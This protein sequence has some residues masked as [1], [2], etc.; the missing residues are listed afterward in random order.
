MSERELSEAVEVLMA[1]DPRHGNHRA[2]LQRIQQLQQQPS[3]FGCCAM[4]FANPSM[5][6]Y[7]RLQA[8]FQLKNNIT[9]RACIENLAVR[10][11]ILLSIG[12]A[13]LA[14]RKTSAAITSAAVRDGAWD[15]AFVITRL[16]ELI[17][18]GG[19][20]GN[21][22]QVHGC[23]LALSQI[24]EDCVQMLDVL[25]LSEAVIHALCPCVMYEGHEK[26][27]LL[28]LRGLT[29]FLE[30]SG[31]DQTSQSYL[32][33]SKCIVPL[34][35]TFFNN[36]QT[37]M[38]TD[39]SESAIKCLVLALTFHTQI[40]EAL[41]MRIATLMIHAS[42]VDSNTMENVRIEATEF[43][44]GVLYFPQFA[45]AVFPALP[46]IIPVLVDGMVYSNMELGMLQANAND[47]S[48]P[49]RPEDI[50]P[51]HYEARTQATNDED[52]D[53]NDDSDEVEEWNLRRVSAVALDDIAEYFGD[54]I[55]DMV[56]QVI[57]QRMQPSE[58]WRQLEAAILA[59]GAVAEGC[60]E[61]LKPYLD[62]I[63]NRLLDILENPGTHF[64]VAVIA[65][66]A[67]RRLASYLLYTQDAQGRLTKLDRYLNC[68]FAR[69]MAPSKLVQEAAC[70]ALTDVADQA[71]DGQLKQ[72]LG[73]IARTVNACLTNYQ[74][75]NRILLFEQIGSLCAVFG[76]SIGET[77]VM[78][79]FL[80]P[81]IV[82]WQQ[83]ANDSP[84][85]FSFFTCMSSVCG[86]LGAQVQPMA[87]GIFDRAYG[88]FHHHMIARQHA[89]QTGDEPPEF[90][91]IVT[92]VD[93]LSGLFDALGSSLEPLVA[94]NQPA[95]LQMALAALTDECHEIRQSG[96][97]LMGDLSKACPRY[98]Q[99]CLPQLF[100]AVFQ[101]CQNLNEYTSGCISNAAWCVRELL[102]HQLD[103][104]GL[105]LVNVATVSN[106]FAQF[107]KLLA[108][109]ELTIDM[110]NMAENIALLIG[111]LIHA[112]P[113]ILQA[114]GVTLDMFVRRWLEYARNVKKLEQRENSARGFLLAVQSNP[115]ALTS[116]LLLFFDYANSLSDCSADIKRAVSGVLAQM[117]A[118]APAV[119]QNAV[120]TFSAQQMNKLFVTYGVK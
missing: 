101:N 77:D 80:D 52:D 76:A 59:L 97:A 99:Q 14:I 112:E 69:M 5:N 105:P 107:V 81:L 1:A 62:V 54:R 119:F 88:V 82:I 83:T 75:K 44:R 70:S 39:I 23:V 40:D 120:Q 13:E 25:R 46:Q 50:K 104:D 58:D 114:V 92:S 73:P 106:I 118:G 102:D 111:A 18:T 60:S 87:K 91:F 110:K 21:V 53:N 2:A 42:Q 89:L 98:V 37:P 56:L 31:A 79:L 51:R 115:A 108:T 100:Q 16:V 113:S 11:S 34:I 95:L 9:N 22:G 27:R 41:F 72:Y 64:L 36:L 57:D 109:A 90:E 7:A 24:T 61:G 49:D 63:T 28:S 74:L 84:L 33:L 26:I 29:C 55:L 12:D 3:F 4:I 45:E 93:L 43:W 96:F 19:A 15:C 32:T 65:T 117:K 68:L 38:S 48:V 86:A 8:G 35:E 47:A 94:E 116:C 78:N 67:L 20:A 85:L 66:W 10:D 17:H 6:N 30:Q 103:M 71:D